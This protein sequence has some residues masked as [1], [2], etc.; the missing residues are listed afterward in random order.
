[1]LACIIHKVKAIEFDYSFSRFKSLKG[2]EK[3]EKDN[4]IKTVILEEYN[5]IDIDKKAEILKQLSVADL[6]GVA[7]FFS[8]FSTEL[9]IQT[10]SR[11]LREETNPLLKAKLKE[12]IHLLK[13]ISIE[14]S[15][16][17]GVSIN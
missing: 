2:K 16:L 8:I 7:F 3:Y 9:S 11:Y 5:S 10:L 13:R 4:Y 6:A 1:M 15:G 12:Q 17:I 14:H